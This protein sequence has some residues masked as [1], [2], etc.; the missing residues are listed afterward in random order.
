MLGVLHRQNGVFY[1][2]VNNKVVGN[3]FILLVSKFQGNR[4]NSLGV[5]VVRSWCT[6]MLTLWNFWIDLGN[7]PILAMIVVESAFGD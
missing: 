6:E 4:P 5:M 3:F 2:I 1:K 7:L